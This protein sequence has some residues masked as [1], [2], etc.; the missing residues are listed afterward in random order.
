MEKVMLRQLKWHINP[1]TPGSFVRLFLHYLNPGSDLI[2][3][4]VLEV[5]E[6]NTELSVVEYYFLRYK[7]SVIAMSSILN[8]CKLKLFLQLLWST[9]STARWR[10]SC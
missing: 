6:W 2:L 10:R 8:A 4:S 3:K 7:P 1:P 9:R 5:T